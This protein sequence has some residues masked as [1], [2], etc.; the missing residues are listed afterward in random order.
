[1]ATAGD[2]TAGWKNLRPSCKEPNPVSSEVNRLVSV[3]FACSRGGPISH[4]AGPP[5]NGELL[6][7]IVKSELF[8]RSLN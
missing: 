1:M 2:Q 8:K 4:A 3:L 7:L 6:V 5:S